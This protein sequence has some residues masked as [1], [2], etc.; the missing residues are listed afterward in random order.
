MDQQIVAD[1]GRTLLAPFGSRTELNEYANRLSLTYRVKLK[2]GET[3]KLSQAE[4]IRF[5]SVCLAHGLDPYAGEIWASEGK[6]GELVIKTGRNGWTKAIAIQLRNEGGGN[7]WAEYRQ[8]VE[9]AERVQLLIPKGA[10]AFE[11]RLYDTPSIRAYTEAV[12]RLSRAGASWDEIKGIVGNRPY[13]SGLGVYQ[14][15]DKTRWQDESYP[16]IER[17]K[18]RAYEAAVKYR[19]ALPFD[20]IEGSDELPREY[21]GPMLRPNDPGEQTI[22]NNEYKP[23]PRDIDEAL[24]AKREAGSKALFGGEV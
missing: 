8:I 7:C 23:N 20:Q 13:S 14:P 5:A 3:R 24:K 15:S 18:K 12:E 6:D 22:D 17:A 16:P 4:S 1:N 2:G 9:E 21:T 10:I 11:C 19:F